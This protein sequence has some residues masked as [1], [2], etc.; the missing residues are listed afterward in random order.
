MRLRRRRVSRGRSSGG[1]TACRRHLRKHSVIGHLMHYNEDLSLSLSPPPSPLSPVYMSAT[2][3][4]F[5]SDFAC[6]YSTKFHKLT[7]SCRYA[8][9]R[10][11]LQNSP[12]TGRPENSGPLSRRQRDAA[13]ASQ[14]QQKQRQRWRDRVQATPKETQRHTSFDALQSVFFFFNSQLVYHAQKQ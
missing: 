3:I 11:P 6:L 10:Y 12:S 14:S 5:M 2:L 1:G 9:W 13:E 4:I 7:A 8:S